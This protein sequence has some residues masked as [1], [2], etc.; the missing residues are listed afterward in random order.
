M[1]MPRPEFWRNVATVITG[2]TGAQALTLLAAPLLT[3]LCTPAEMGS[4]S[5]WLGVIAV[6]SIVATLRVENAMVIDHGRQQQ[7]LC[8]G[9]V[10]YVATLLAVT[11]TLGSLCACALGLPSLKMVSWPAMAAVGLA[12][13]ISANIQTTLAYAA[14]HRRFGT[15]ARIKLLQAGTIAVSQLALL[16][17]GVDGVALLAGQLIGLCARLLA[18]RLLLSPPRP[19]LRFFLDRAQR[20]YLRKHQ[21]FWRYSLPSSL[22]N[23]MVGQLPLFMIGIHHGALAAGLFALTQRVLAAPT[24]LIAT[25]ILEVFKRQAVSEFESVGN[26]VA[27]YRSTFKALVLL[28]LPPTLVLLLFSPALFAWLFGDDWRAA[29]DLARILAPLCFLNFVASP[30][31]YVFFVAGK[32]RMELFWQVA[33]FL[34]T[35]TVFVAPLSLHGSLFAYAVVRSM[36][37]L[38]YLYMSHMCARNGPVPA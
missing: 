10:A 4:F 5:V 3:R 23:T 21:A 29:G 11:L 1:S 14:S 17:A 26:C 30:L 33:L 22:L 36:L 35:L 13:W 2:A 20:D 32:Q 24:A 34:A 19:R 15:A 18:G 28:A 7:R 27:V 16:Y 12:T 25:S 9:V 31:S 6:T 37:Y 38:I 8:F